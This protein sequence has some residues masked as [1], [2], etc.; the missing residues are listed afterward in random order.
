MADLNLRAILR[1]VDHFSGPLKKAL[2]AL[3]S[4]SPLLAAIGLTSLVSSL[5]DG[6]RNLV[7]R[8]LDVNGLFPHV[9][10]EPVAGDHRVMD[11][12]RKTARSGVP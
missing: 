4:V 9:R 8:V 10:G 7:S 1:L 2:G 5:G 12:S 11:W 3:K 6:V